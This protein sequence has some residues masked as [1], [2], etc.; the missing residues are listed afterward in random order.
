MVYA[1]AFFVVLLTQTSCIYDKSAI[2]PCGLEKTESLVINLNLTVPASSTGTRSAGD[3]LVPGSKDENYINIDGDYQVLLFDKD[4]ALVEDKLS[5]FECK[6]N[7]VNG[8]MTSYTL[9]T[10]L[11]LSGKEDRERLSTFK[12]MVLANWKSFENSN[13][14]ATF[15]YP[16][17]EGYNLSGTTNNIYKERA[18]FNFTFATPTTESPNCWR[19][20]IN[21]K[22]A[23]PMFG[24]TEDGDLQ[25]AID[26][27][28]YGDDPSFSVPMLRSLAK[29]EIVDMVPDGKSANIDKCVLT[30]YNT[31]GRFIPDITDENSEWYEIKTQIKQPSLPDNVGTS[32]NLK[33]YKTTKTVSIE[34]SATDKDCFVVYIPEMEIDKTD[35]PIIQ[36]QLGGSDYAYPIYLQKYEN[37]KPKEGDEN[38]YDNLLRN[39]I[40]RFNITNVGIDMELTITTDHWDVDDDQLW[41]YEDAEPKFDEAFTWND[42]AG[43][44]WGTDESTGKFDT[45]TDKNDMYRVL[46]IGS[47]ADTAAYGYF[48]LSTPADNNPGTWTIALVSDDGTNND[49]F[50]IEVE[51]SLGQWESQGQGDSYTASIGDEPVKFRIMATA[52][53]GSSADYTARVVMVVKTFDGRLVNIPLRSKYDQFQ[54][55]TI[56]NPDDPRFYFMV[57]QLTN[58][59]DNM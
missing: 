38:K 24:I 52:T 35:S 9:T 26:M 2:M 58:G 42:Y 20:S 3:D 43:N 30:K 46:L 44:P 19:P 34:G 39:H 29:I 21:D 18:K 53:N 10:K 40:Y 6:E 54:N 31:S 14:D 16:S 13:T 5:E 59:G 55:L 28:K 15:E 8:E 56:T 4:G 36:V 49:H 48:N 12:V 47:S 32:T 27:A 23:I 37:G 57:K 41:D 11:S 50:K 45:Y 25:F 22:R 7:G 17:F 33:F 1:L 51:T